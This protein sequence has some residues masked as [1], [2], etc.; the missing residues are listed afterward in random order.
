MK[1]Y[2]EEAIAAA[3]NGDVKGAFEILFQD[4]T[5][6]AKSPIEFFEELI[7]YLRRTLDVGS[8]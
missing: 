5:A 1:L 4:L 7:D 2:I 6:N 8:Y 3:M